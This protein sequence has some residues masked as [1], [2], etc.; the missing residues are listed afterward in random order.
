MSAS[1]PVR[2]APAAMP[3]AAVYRPALIQY[4]RRKTRDQTEIEDLVQDVFLR[5]AAR[6]SGEAVENLA[7]YVFQTAA[8]VL[9]DRHR[10]RTVRHADAHV[11]FDT[12]RHGSTDFDAVRILE[13]RQSLQ[14]AVAALQSLPERTRTIF[15]LRRLEGHAY[16]DIASQFGISVSAVEKHMVRAVQH[17]VSLS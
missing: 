15:V 14:K 7:G 16:R 1:D 17:L 4:F 6:R 13:A 2:G 3:E 5:I 10:R 11:E 8:S 9:A 12:E